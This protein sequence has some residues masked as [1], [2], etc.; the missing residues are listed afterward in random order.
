[1]EY[2]YANCTAKNNKFS[3]FIYPQKLIGFI[4]CFNS[5]LRINF[6]LK[7]ETF[8]MKKVKIQARQEEKCQ[9]FSHANFFH[10]ISRKYKEVILNSI[11]QH[12]HHRGGQTKPS[13]YIVPIS[14]FFFQLIQWP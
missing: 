7:N 1:M 3:A 5:L 8:Y 11:K 12:R 9:C 2:V 13:P 6:V 10:I 4:T 14:S